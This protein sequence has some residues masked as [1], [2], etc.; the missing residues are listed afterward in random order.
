MLAAHPV[1]AEIFPYQEYVPIHDGRVREEHEALAHLGIDGT[2]VYRREDPFWDYFTPPWGYQCR[3]GVNLLGI[4]DAARLGVREASEWLETGVKPPLRS[5]L[6]EIPFKPTDGFGYRGRTSVA[7]RMATQGMLFETG[8]NKTLWEQP[9]P[10]PKQPDNPWQPY[11]G[12]RGGKGWKHAGTGVI[13]YQTERPGA[14]QLSPQHDDPLY[15][16]RSAIRRT[17]ERVNNPQSEADHRRRAIWQ[18]LR[19]EFGDMAGFLAADVA[20]GPQATQSTI[21]QR[22]SEYGLTEDKAMPLAAAAA[23]ALREYHTG[24]GEFATPD[25]TAET[26]EELAKQRNRKYEEYVRRAEAQRAKRRDDAIAW[27]HANIDYAGPLHQ[28]NDEQAGALHWMRIERKTR[29]DAKD[30]IELKN[31]IENWRAEPEKADQ[32][33]KKAASSHWKS[34][35]GKYRYSWNRDD[36]KHKP[37]YYE[38]SEVAQN[39]WEE[40]NHKLA[41]GRWYSF[42]GTDPIKAHEEAV[43]KACLAGLAHEVPLEYLRDHSYKSWIPKEIKAKL[44]TEDRVKVFRDYRDGPEHAQNLRELQAAQNA[45]REALAPVLDR[46][47]KLA[48]MLRDEA[49]YD[50]LRDE[51]NKLSAKHE[52]NVKALD[53][54]AATITN[55]K[56]RTHYLMP[57]LDE[58]PPQFLDEWKRRTAEKQAYYSADRVLNQKMRDMKREAS[59]DWLWSVMGDDQATGEGDIAFEQGEFLSDEGRENLS[60]AA[61]F[62]QRLLG[63]RLGRVDVGMKLS[64]AEDGRAS[65]GDKTMNLF[66]SSGATT[67]VHEVGHVIDHHAGNEISRLS[68]TYCVKRLAESNVEPKW[69]GEGYDPWEIMHQDGLRDEYCGKFYPHESS[70]ILSMGCQ[71]LYADAERFFAEDPDHFAFTLAAVRGLLT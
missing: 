23:K 55:N 53:Y 29:K 15:R 48:P 49:A 60:D 69:P 32:A 5:R 65:A 3:C 8:K 43:E 42:D 20:H 59:Q 16:R 67:I 2:G 26:P 41:T 58:I 25:E 33:A 37:N 38:A 11:T 30:F 47:G 10:K 39:M 68:K 40:A 9:K 6:A 45:A 63:K 34:R 64:T 35:F 57:R 14:E 1:V 28:L 17:Q 46:A 19:S 52:E 13:V 7:V 71:Y 50:A 66:P 22:F 24:R 51:R 54:L 61:A 70:E 36:E 44:D 18:A 4:A 27:A 31:T 62:L 21:L 56:I 12:P